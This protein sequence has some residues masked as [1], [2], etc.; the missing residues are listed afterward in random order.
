MAS[1]TSLGSLPFVLETNVES[2]VLLDTRSSYHSPRF[3][4]CGIKGSCFGHSERLGLCWCKRVLWRSKKVRPIACKSF[5]KDE[6]EDGSKDVVHATIEK[7]KK[8][9]ALQRDLLQQISERKKLISSIDSD[10]ISKPE[11]G[12]I[13]YEHGTNGRSHSFENQNGNILGIYGGFDE[14]NQDVRVPPPEPASLRLDSLPAFFTNGTENSSL[15]VKNQDGVIESSLENITDESNEIGSE[16]E[17]PQPLAGTNV[18]NV[19]V[20][21]AECAPWSKT[22]GLGD[23]VGSLPKALAKR[24]HRVMVVAPRYGNYIE[25]QD[26][27]VRKTYRVD[28]HDMEVRYFQAYIDGVDFVFIESPMFHN[29]EH[30][31][32]A[33]SRL[34]ILKRMIL[35]CKAAVEVPWHVPCGGVCYGDGNLAFI[36]ND[37]HTSLLPVYLKAYY[38]DQGLMKYTRSVLVIH[39]IAHQGRGPVDDFFYVDLAEHYIDLFKLYDP[40]GGDHFNIFAAGLKSADRVVTVSHGYSWELKTSEG[41]WGLHGIINDNGWKLRGIVNGI[42]NKDWN[43]KFDVHLK[44]DGYTN[45]SLETL[46]TGKPQCKAALQKELGLPVR[47]DIPVIGFIGRL[48]PQ[49]GV[50]LIAEAVPWMMGQDVQLI[51][52]GSGRPDLEQMLRNFENQHNDKIRSWV[53]FSVKTAHRIT[54]GADILLMP[55]RFE[56]C[57]LNQL[58]AM[59][60]G[61]VP[62]VH[63]VGGL[64]D[65][66]KPFD[67]FNETGLGWTFG[68][69][70]SGKLIHALGNCLLTYREYKESWE[71][72]QR[73]G[74][75]Q[76]LSWDNAAQQYEEVLLAA[77]YQ[78]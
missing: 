74:M 28:G 8:V 19:I 47:E 13:S 4:V 3:P 48:D 66:V 38:R 6:Y 10:N 67:P 55:S 18:M 30:N 15:K 26:T 51:M 39:N 78:W 64:R 37:W 24:G 21:A 52:L 62:V 22:G 76:D 2:L 63:A 11:G 42:D 44:S 12:S 57:G 77:K 65:T 1:S 49:K 7:R 20:V 73:R 27:G 40:I 17:I 60:Y 25:P 70:E 5:G 33:G 68:S 9:L 34:D 69:A 32:Y 35:F 14:S 43:P 16:G 75:T 36:A 31:I 71:G 29:L 23:V 54:A 59:A 50:D 56:P 72:L 61:T 53:G 45:Y 58:Y 46:H 41:G